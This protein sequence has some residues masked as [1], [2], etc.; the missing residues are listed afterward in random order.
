MKK[1]FRVALALMIVI[2]LVAA[3]G[4]GS[5]APASTQNQTPAPTQA[6]APEKVLKV[7]SDIT[8][9]PFESF[10][11]KQ[12]ATGFDIDLMKAVGEDLGYKV[13]FETSAFDGLI[14][15]LQ[16][17]KYDCVIS[18]MTI[19]QERA[20]SVK[21]SDPYFKAVQYIAY[22][23]G[24]TY[25]KIADLKGK[26]VG[27]QL[28]TTGQFAVEDKGITTKKFDTT[29]DALNALLI[30]GVDAVV[31]DNQPV[32]SFIDANQASNI[33]CVTADTADEFYGIAFKLDNTQLA[34][35]VNATLKKFKEN[36][37]YAEIYKKYFKGD[38]PKL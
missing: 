27:V 9:P 2:S 4:C 34:D 22:K 37:K 28:N 25:T 23:K 19:T 10:D 11:A 8:Y 29:P 15:S 17:G 6:P 18:A 1:G 13:Q 38:V 3:A 12:Q 7:G 26:K 33:E 16:A 32:L 5:S 36:G 20:K 35:Q 30:G 24:A 14:P 21:F 31:A